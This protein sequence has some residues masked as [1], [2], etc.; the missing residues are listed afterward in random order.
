MVAPPLIP[1]V[2]FE[3]NTGYTLLYNEIFLLEARKSNLFQT[4][5]RSFPTCMYNRSR[6]EI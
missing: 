1:Y 2:Q 4:R 3:K 6:D 5:S